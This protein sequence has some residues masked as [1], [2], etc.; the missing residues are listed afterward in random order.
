MIE[1]SFVEE[2]RRTKTIPLSFNENSCLMFVHATLIHAAGTWQRVG[3]T[4]TKK[5]PIGPFIPGV[6]D[7]IGYP[8]E[9]GGWIGRGFALPSLLQKSRDLTEGTPSLVAGSVHFYL[10]IATEPQMGGRP[11]SETRQR[12]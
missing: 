5:G 3:I 2:P 9:G 4:A 1:R 8:K 6:E 7:Q 10:L 12:E 11:V